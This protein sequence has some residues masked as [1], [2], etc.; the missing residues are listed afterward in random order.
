MI[1]ATIHQVTGAEC[2]HLN[3]DFGIDHAAEVYVA[4]L[5]RRSLTK[6]SVLSMR[7]STERNRT[8][9]LS[10]FLKIFSRKCRPVSINEQL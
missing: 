7:S 8:E 5:L 1:A 4:T 6:P 3:K 2:L 9:Q 10:M